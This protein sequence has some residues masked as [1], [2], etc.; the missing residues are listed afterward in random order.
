[1]LH[2]TLGSDVCVCVFLSLY[3]TSFLFGQDYQFPDR[4]RV[5]II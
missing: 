2:L 4:E 3:Y 5:N 1:M